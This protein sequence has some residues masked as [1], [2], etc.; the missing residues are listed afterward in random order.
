MKY[1]NFIKLS[2]LIILDYL[3]S[4]DPIFSSRKEESTDI[5]SISGKLNFVFLGFLI[6]SMPNFFTDFND[7]FNK[8][9]I[10]KINLILKFPII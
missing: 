7:N 9:F 4:F 10:F 3:K 8:L 6:S 5:S 2:K 1:F